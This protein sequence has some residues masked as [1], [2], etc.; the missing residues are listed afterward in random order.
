MTLTNDEVYLIGFVVSFI[1][2]LAGFIL[3]HYVCYVNANK[4]PMEFTEDATSAYTLI[5]SKMQK[6]E[7]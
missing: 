4:K 6:G 7:Q 3:G 2:F 1:T 5:D